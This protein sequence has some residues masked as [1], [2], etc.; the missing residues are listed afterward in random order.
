[1]HNAI[2]S[3]LIKTIPEYLAARA[4]YFDCKNPN[5]QEANQLAIYKVWRSWIL[6]DQRQIHLLVGRWIWTREPPDYK[7]STLRRLLLNGG[8]ETS[9]EERCLYFFYLLT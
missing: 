7:S 1:M 8:Y 2:R 9:R 3:P 5:W 6:D 4:G